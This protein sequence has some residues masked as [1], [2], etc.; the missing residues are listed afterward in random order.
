MPKTKLYLIGIVLVILCSCNTTKNS[1]V[2]IVNKI[3]EDHAT[4]TYNFPEGVY[5]SYIFENQAYDFDDNNLIIKLIGEDIPL[6]NVWFKRG[7][8]SCVPPGSDI[9]MQVIVKPVLLVQLSESNDKMESLGFKFVTE[10]S[11][12]N[13]AYRVKHYILSK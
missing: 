2:S 8:S 3:D 10:P 13:C 6:Q 7:S 9:A 11:T 12:G 1:Q 4:E 5:Y